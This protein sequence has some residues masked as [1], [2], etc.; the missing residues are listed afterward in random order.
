MAWQI[1]NCLFTISF[2]DPSAPSVRSVAMQQ[3][4]LKR[5]QNSQDNTLSGYIGSSTSTS[6]RSAATSVDN[7]SFASSAPA[8][9]KGSEQNSSNG[10]GDKPAVKHCPICKKSFQKVCNTQ[11]EKNEK[12]FCE[13]EFL[14]FKTVR[15]KVWKVRLTEIP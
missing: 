3:R 8:S 13:T 11:C 9:E 6:D 12:N 14:V 7:Q 4:L 2:P 5:K 15:I 10:D 1:I